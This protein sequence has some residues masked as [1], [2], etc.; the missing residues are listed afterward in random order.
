MNLRVAP[1][2]RAANSLLLL[3]FSARCRA[4]RLDVCGVDHLRL[5][6]PSGPGKLSEEIFPD[7][8]PCPAREAVIDGGIR[9]ILGWAIAPAAA[10]LQH[11]NDS[12]DHAAIILTLDAAH[13]RWQVWFNPISLL[14][15]QPKQIV[16][17]DPHPLFKT[18]QGRIV[19]A[20]QLMSFDPSKGLLSSLKPY[21]H[22]KPSGSQWIGEVPQHWRIRNFRA[23]IKRRNERNHPELP[24]LSVARER[25]VFIRSSDGGDENH[26]VIP[27]DLRNYK[28]AR[29]GDLVINKMK[30]WQ[31]SMGLAPCDG[32]VSPAY[33]VFRFSIGNKRFGQMLLRS[34]PYVAQFAQVSDGVRVGQWDLSIDGMRGIPIVE[35]ID[36]EQ[37]AIVRFLV[38]L[39]IALMRPF[40]TR[41]G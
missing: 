10:G 8:T 15:A 9:A 31:G 23:L 6:S 1:S 32:I 14:I 18:N 19:R 38:I 22:Y 34:K 27:E 5:F 12:A 41:S 39:H 28:V 35:P 21:L 37:E 40:A 25:G 33:F 36:G 26:N 11:V 16:A 24:L 13:I 2:A 4:V 20:Q 29:A 7:A 30:A 3:P 17:H